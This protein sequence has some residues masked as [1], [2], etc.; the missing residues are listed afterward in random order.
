LLASKIFGSPALAMADE[1]AAFRQTGRW[2]LDADPMAARI[3][4]TKDS[5]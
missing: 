3:A 2:P 5:S 4:G 1:A